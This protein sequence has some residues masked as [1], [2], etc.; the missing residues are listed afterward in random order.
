M[1]KIYPQLDLPDDKTPIWRYLDF[2]K[3]VSLLD[4]SSL[5]FT[6]SDKLGDPF[7]GSYPNATVL[8]RKARAK[9]K[10]SSDRLFSQTMAYFPQFTAINCWH[11]NEIE[12]TAMWKTYLK[13]DEGISIKSTVKRLKTCFDDV[14][15]NIYI[16]KVKYVDYKKDLID[17]DDYNLLTPYFYKRKVSNM[18]E[19]L[20][21]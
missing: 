16:G 14:K 4:T 19:K 10:G 13:S 7:E 15:Y 3:F 18:N 5:Y 12:S 6:R 1:Y 17:D 8:L 20:E 21:Q 11:I 9:R 2:T